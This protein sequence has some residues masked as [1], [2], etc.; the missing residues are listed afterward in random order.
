MIRLMLISPVILLILLVSV[1][2]L[3]ISIMPEERVYNC[4]IAEISPDIP[5]VVKNECRRLRM[6]KP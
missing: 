1:V 3:L 5:I 2:F 4:D 6:N